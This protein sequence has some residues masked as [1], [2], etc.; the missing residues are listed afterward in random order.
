MTTKCL[1]N[2]KVFLFFATYFLAIAINIQVSKH[3][4]LTN[5]IEWWLNTLILYVF[6]LTCI[7]TL[8]KRLK[9]IYKLGLLISI[10]FI[11]AIF[12]T[13]KAFLL[14]IL[15]FDPNHIRTQGEHRAIFIL[16]SLPILFYLIKKSKIFLT[17]K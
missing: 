16:A 11:H 3:L 1:N 10:W 13:P 12:T 2:K 8:T 9:P 4:E 6:V 17:E 14:G 5:T 15:K 7:A